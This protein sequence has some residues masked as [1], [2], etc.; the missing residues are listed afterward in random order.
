MLS[1]LRA[2]R[3]APTMIGRKRFKMDWGKKGHGRRKSFRRF[4]ARR[5]KH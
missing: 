5:K 1:R 2:A 3:A 4:G